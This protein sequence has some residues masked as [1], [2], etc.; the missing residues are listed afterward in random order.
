MNPVWIGIVLAAFGLAANV[1]DCACDPARPEAMTARQCSLCVEAERH[2]AEAPYFFLKD[3]SPYKPNRWLMLLRAHDYDGR[4]P[5]VKLAPKQRTAFWKA[6]IERARELW[7]DGWGI[8]FNGDAVR[9]Q[10]HAHIHIGRLLRGVEY[11][12]PLVVDGP[13]QIPAPED[14]TGFWI[15]P[16]GNKLHVHMGELRAETV[17]YR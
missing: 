5:L 1:D 11:G 17:L 12:K 15:H 13:A 7:G 2:P 4:L 16:S 14:G 8:A 9:T 10:C 3:S 6:A